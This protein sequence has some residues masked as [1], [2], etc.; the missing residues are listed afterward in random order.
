MY[1]IEDYLI[2][3]NQKKELNL[4]DI[5]K[6]ICDFYLRFEDSYKIPVSWTFSFPVKSLR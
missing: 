5:S 3:N 6:I 2:K 4:V 1:L